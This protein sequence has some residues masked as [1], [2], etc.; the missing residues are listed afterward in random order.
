MF[1]LFLAIESQLSRCL[2]IEL[3]FK[4]SHEILA[5]TFGSGNS[6]GAQR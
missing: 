5:N 1:F 4:E 6:Q 2:A 3:A